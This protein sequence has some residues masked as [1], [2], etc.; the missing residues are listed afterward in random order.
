[1]NALERRTNRID[2]AWIIV[3]NT[4]LA[5]GCYAVFAWLWPMMRVIALGLVVGVLP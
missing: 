4:L 2:W 3:G 1:M 5:V